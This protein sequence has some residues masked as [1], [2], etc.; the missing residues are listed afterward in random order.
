[1]DFDLAKLYIQTLKNSLLN[2]L[3]IE[4]EARIVQ[5]LARTLNDLDSTFE[6][7]YVPDADLQASIHEFKQGGG[8]TVLN[9]QDEDGSL[10]PG[11]ELRNYTELAHTMIGRKRLDNIQF[12][13]EEVIKLGIP[14]D[15]I[16]T[17]IWR[18]GAT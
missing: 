12:C 18:G 7:I 15:L 8:T 10:P 5:V 2:E 9:R 13:I 1:M 3:Y 16:E 14:G 6:D 17:G 11:Y 4:N